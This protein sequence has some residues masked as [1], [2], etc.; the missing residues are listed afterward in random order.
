VNYGWS[1]AAEQAAVQVLRDNLAKQGVKWTDFALVQH[2]SGANISVVNMIA[3]GTP[4][5]VFMQT[6][7]GL[8]SHSVHRIP[9][10]CFSLHTFTF[11]ALFPR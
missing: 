2:D 6:D 5:D 11:A 10:C 8:I 1:A 4:P 9:P 7:P 3:G